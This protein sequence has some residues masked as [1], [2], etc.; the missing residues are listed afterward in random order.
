MRKIRSLDVFVQVT[1]SDDLTVIRNFFDDRQETMNYD[2]GI[3]K[4]IVVG[5]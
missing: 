1:D 2:V 3:R 4:L 5:Y